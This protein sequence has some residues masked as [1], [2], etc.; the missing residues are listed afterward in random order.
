MAVVPEP[1]ELKEPMSDAPNNELRAIF[2]DGNAPSL[3]SV[4]KETRQRM[5][6]EAGRDLARERAELSQ[7][8]RT[9]RIDPEHKPLLDL[10]AVVG[11]GCLLLGAAS[12]AFTTGVH[13][14]SLG[15]MGLGALLLGGYAAMDWA[16]VR[17]LVTSR[18]A[19]YSANL[20][21]T[22]SMLLAILVV[23]NLLANRYFHVFDFTAQQLNSL[24][25][26]SAQLMKTLKESGRE[27]TVT[28]FYPKDAEHRQAVRILEE[29][30][31]RY[32]VRNPHI[33]FSIV[34]PDI[35]KKLA[36]EKGVTKAFTILFEAGNNETRINSF[37]EPSITSAFLKVTSPESKVVYFITGHNEYRI[38][39]DEQDGLDK[40]N[41]YLGRENLVVKELSIPKE[42][43][44]PADAAAVALIRP[45]ITPLQ[46]QE[47]AALKDY[48]DRGGNLMVLVEPFQ[49]PEVVAW[50]EPYGIKVR[51]DMVID[52]ESN[53]FNEATTPILMPAEGDHPLLPVTVM[54]SAGEA[55]LPDA[56]V[57]PSARS[58]E[59][60]SGKAT[61]TPLY[62]T[63]SIV[64]FGETRQN[65]DT[66]SFTEGEDI[67]GPL[68]V[69]AAGQMQG[70][71]TG[72][73]LLIAGDA[74]WLTNDNIS[75]EFNRDFA[76]NSLAWLVGSEQQIAIRPKEFNTQKANLKGSALQLVSATIFGI[77]VLVACL[78]V[79]VWWRRRTW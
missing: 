21:I 52:L 40:L 22:L 14:A 44:I 29:I 71:E 24:S 60:G 62:G 43:G 68:V 6:Q 8:L 4:V 38:T 75:R 28:A 5:D 65:S 63:G 34:D 49:A 61:W 50:L 57:T 12:M 1:E 17:R 11:F 19:L 69:V 23:T 42:N 10:A 74:Q 16:R 27:I 56:L 36:E 18:S 41:E 76:V 67:P 2:Q 31:S 72:G 54:T 77:P 45:A 70:T 51:Q 47:F 3:E 20:A 35:N 39:N 73:R 48:L 26:Q 55:G 53:Y 25:P 30:F 59:L 46:N 33:K 7:R 13:P 9:G 37:D 78:G 79:A 58:L 32:T 66:P 64:S 15:L